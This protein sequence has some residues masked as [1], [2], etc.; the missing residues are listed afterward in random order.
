M[1]ILSPFL[2]FTIK[3]TLEQ[4]ILMSLRH[5]SNFAWSHLAL[6][7]SPQ[8]WPHTSISWRDRALDQKWILLGQITYHIKISDLKS[9]FSKSRFLPFSPV[10]A[11]VIRYSKFLSVVAYKHSYSERLSWPCTLLTP[12]FLYYWYGYIFIG[13]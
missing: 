5:F 13:T 11:L 2:R 4:K 10:R 3:I 12:L 1:S 7:P 9:V 6:L 8:F